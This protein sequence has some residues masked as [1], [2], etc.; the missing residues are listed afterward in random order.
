MNS[1]TVLFFIVLCIGN[2]FFPQIIERVMDIIEHL[3]TPDMETFN[4]DYDHFFM[5]SFS[6]VFSDYF[7]DQ[8]AAAR[9][10]KE[11]YEGRT[12]KCCDTLIKFSSFKFNSLMR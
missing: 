10:L 1:S 5:C 6:F 2:V 3:K 9:F 11:S 7:N 8:P 4:T 12:M